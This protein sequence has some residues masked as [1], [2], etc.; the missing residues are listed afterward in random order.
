LYEDW[1]YEGTGFKDYARGLNYPSTKVNLRIQI[2]PANRARQLVISKANGE[3][4]EAVGEPVTVAAGD[5]VV[6]RTVEV[7]PMEG[8]SLSLK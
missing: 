2:P 4:F 7:S 5:K 8:F 6:E 3:G 1:A